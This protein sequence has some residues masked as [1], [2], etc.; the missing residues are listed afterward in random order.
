MPT[1]VLRLVA[2][3]WRDSICAVVVV[4]FC[5]ATSIAQ[6]RRDVAYAT[7]PSQCAGCHT[8]AARMVYRDFVTSQPAEVWTQRDK[9]S[10]AF[11]NLVSLGNI[12]LTNRIL[13]FP[14]QDAFA[15]LQG[16]LP[17]L[18][19][20]ASEADKSFREWANSSKVDVKKFSDKAEQVAVVQ[21][22]MRC[23]GTMLPAE[24]ALAGQV[25]ADAPQLTAAPVSPMLGVS[26]EAC[27]GPAKAWYVDHSIPYWRLVSGEEKLKFGLRD[28]RDPILK[29][30]LC[31][32]CHVG[33]VEQ[34]KFVKHE[35][36]AKGHPPLPSF[37]L[38]SFAEQMPGH[39]V[40]LQQKGDFQGR[41]ADKPINIDAS[42]DAFKA[43]VG[44]VLADSFLTANYPNKPADFDPFSQLPRFQEALIGGVVSFQSHVGLLTGINKHPKG[45]A[46]PFADFSYFD[47]MSCHHELKNSATGVARPVR[48]GVAGRPPLPLWPTMLLQAAVAHRAEAQGLPVPD[49]LKKFNG[50]LADLELAMTRRPFGDAPAIAKSAATM[51]TYL[52]TLAVDLRNSRFDKPAAL[53]ALQM[54]TAQGIETRDYAAARHLAWGLDAI[55]KDIDGIKYEP[56]VPEADPFGPIAN[57]FRAQE[58][59][60]ALKLPATKLNFIIRELPNNLRFGA[61][62]KPEQFD[63]DLKRIRDERFSTSVA[64]AP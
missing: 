13:G 27:H 31:S 21:A 41:T 52:G 47:C 38:S 22:C 17:P 1:S 35:W 33:N 54:L 45:E 53:K 61:N 46:P 34:G 20:S 39:W 12:D 6:E 4:I 26:C 8:D 43:D 5:G 9:H 50:L 14:L 63:A 19:E 57:I 7:D 42:V 3:F 29:A 28:L 49:E 40:P 59:Y 60:L 44:D 64:P 48:H 62:Y 55:G 51:H 25:P 18:P 32:S 15:T 56:F 23:H 36:Y 30:Q 16:D 37:E 10:E 24:F 58:D 11:K 2:G